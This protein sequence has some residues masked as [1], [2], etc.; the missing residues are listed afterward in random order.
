MNVVAA[1]FPGGVQLHTH[2]RET[3]ER[4]SR[5]VPLPKQIV[6]PLQQHIGLPAEPRV[7]V[8][9]TVL[10][11]QIIADSRHYVSVPLHASTSGRVI[12]IGQRPVGQGSAQCIVIEP[13]GQDT[14]SD[15][16]P[17]KDYWKQDPEVLHKQIRAC[18]I[19]GLGGAGFPAHVKVQ[20]GVENEVHTL[21]INGVEC[22]PYITCDD[23][24]IREK[25]GYVVKGTRMLAHALKAGRSIIAVEEDMP[26]AI[27]A[28]E[29]AIDGDDIEL[30]GV[31]TCYPAGGE[32][33]L[34]QALTGREVPSGGLA[35]HIGV[36]V[37]NVATAAAVYRAVTRGEPVVSR[38]VTV[39]G[40][41]REPGNLQ[42]LLGSPVRDCLEMCGYDGKS[43]IVLGG[44]MMGRL[45]ENP[46]APV[47]KTVNCILV[48]EEPAVGTTV[49]QPCIRC[50]NC[51]DVCPVQ[52]MP[53]EL[54]RL[55]RAADLETLRELH[56][57]DCIECG[58]CAYVCPSNIPLVEDYRNAKAAIAEQERRRA[59]A[60]KARARFEARSARLHKEQLQ[61]TPV[62]P[63]SDA[64]E[65]LE[66]VKGA[67]R[68]HKAGHDG[69]PPQSA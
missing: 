64:A 30:I 52:L 11:G 16:Q 41:V 20:E 55:A 37:Q 36:V 23:R 40:A 6:L 9:E 69:E 3:S 58:C 48:C 27:S 1:G 44:P 29:Q 66:Y 21:I 50:G 10:K 49:E 67:A 12:D 53:H 43:G 59:G 13:D 57:F 26:E 18:G 31:A 25:A 28:L 33:Q 46:A 62:S 51:V 68:R 5:M 8:G 65:R 7:S 35:I 38:Y 14:W 17:T 56:L 2:K 4:V 15:I 42:V 34:V 60:D 22:E 32:K 19:V 24:L 39:T 45:L 61:R 63:P 54:H 47:T